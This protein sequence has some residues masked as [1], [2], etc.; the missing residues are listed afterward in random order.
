MDGTLYQTENDIIQQANLDAINELRKQGVLVC[1]ATGRP[2]NQMK[3]ILE[4]IKFDYMVLINGGYVLDKEQR[5]LYEN[6]LNQ[7]LPMRLYLGA[8]LTKADLCFILVILL[9]FTIIFIRCI[10]SVEIIMYRLFIL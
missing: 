5:L 7:K 4:R 6:P 1:A 3:L 8:I 10:T 9:I 2:L